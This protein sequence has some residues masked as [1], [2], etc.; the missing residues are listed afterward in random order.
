MVAGIAI[1]FRVCTAFLMN[2]ISVSVVKTL[3]NVVGAFAGMWASYGTFCTFKKV[4]RSNV[5]DL[6]GLGQLTVRQIGMIFLSSLV[7]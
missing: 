7:A 1:I 5:D 6:Q 2:G 3:G 4:I